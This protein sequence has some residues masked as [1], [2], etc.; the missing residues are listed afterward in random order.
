[1]N[2]LINIKTGYFG[3]QFGFGNSNSHGN[4]YLETWGGVENQNSSS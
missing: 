3:Q 1:M 2:K 4:G